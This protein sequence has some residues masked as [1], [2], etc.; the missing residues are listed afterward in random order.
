[1][2]EQPNVPDD[3][4][5]SFESIERVLQP[6]ESIDQTHYRE[7]AER[8]VARGHDVMSFDAWMMSGRPFK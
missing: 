8:A 2:N 6:R 4:D 1:M 3:G 5:E 7:Y